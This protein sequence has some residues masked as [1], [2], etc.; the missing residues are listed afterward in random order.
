MAQNGPDRVGAN[1][2]TGIAEGELEVN[3][4][5]PPLTY[6]RGPLWRPRDCVALVANQPYNFRAAT[7]YRVQPEG[8]LGRCPCAASVERSGL[9]PR[10]GLHRS[11]LRASL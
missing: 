5:A 9:S 6:F 3:P 11:T 2:R 4:G 7:Q 10:A 1:P 8:D